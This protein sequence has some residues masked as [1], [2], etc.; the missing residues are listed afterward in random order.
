APGSGPVL[1]FADFEHDDAGWT[2][3]TPHFDVTVT[4]T[5]CHNTDLPAVHGNDCATCH[6]TPYDTIKTETWNKGCQQGGCHTSYHDESTIAHLAWENAYNSSGNDCAICHIQSSWAVTEEQCKN[7][8]AAFAPGDVSPPTTSTDAL[9]TYVGPAKIGFSISDNGKVGVGRT[10][11]QLDGGAVTAAGKHLFV[12]NDAAGQHELKFWSKDQSGNTELTQNTV[13]F[14]VVEDTAPPTTNSDAQASYSQGAVITLTATDAST[15]GVKNTYY[16]INGGA[17]Q[18]GTRVEIPAASGTL[19]YTLTF[20]SEDWAGNVEAQHSVSFTVTS[21]N[22]ILRLVWGDS[23]VN[24]SPCA[25]DPEAWADWTVYR[26]GFS[27]PV[28]AT[29]SGSCPNWDGVDDVS[30]PV[31]YTYSV[32]VNW[33]DSYYGYD[34]QTDFPNNAVTTPGQVIRLSY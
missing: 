22:G 28:V 5:I 9:A 27:G 3:G 12:G 14:S 24:G 4:C 30:V 15:L 16:S 13:Y 33:W 10:F 8:H 21:G 29:G 17:P 25:G 18:T 6:P 32:R 23:D 1:I 31:G 26:G 11:Y 2:N 20:W 7:C 34:D 19:S